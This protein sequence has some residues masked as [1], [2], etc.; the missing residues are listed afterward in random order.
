MPSHKTSELVENGS[1]D[2]YTNTFKTKGIYPSGHCIDACSE[3]MGWA[4]CACSAGAGGSALRMG[5]SMADQEEGLHEQNGSSSSTQ[6]VDRGTGMS[7][8]DYY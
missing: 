6:R 2:E 8:R 5:R 4:R 7:L 1:M 3:D